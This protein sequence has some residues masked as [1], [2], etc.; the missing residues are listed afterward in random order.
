MPSIG[1]FTRSFAAIIGTEFGSV[2]K[3]QRVLRD[4][5]LLT[6]G[7]RGINAPELVPLDAARMLIAALVTDKPSLAPLAVVEF[8]NLPAAD[9]MLSARSEEGEIFA[10]WTDKMTFEQALAFLIEAASTAPPEHRQIL[11]RNI[12]VTCDPTEMKATL[13]WRDGSC[14]YSAGGPWL[15]LLAEGKTDRLDEVAAAQESARLRARAFA[16]YSAR[17]SI[18]RKMDGDL[19]L[20]VADLFR[21]NN[22]EAASEARRAG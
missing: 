18:N 11:T 9:A 2:M 22:I 17:I 19:L 14:S 20:E 4:A 10:G 7:A 13:S 21:S 6:T 1:E 8:G 12:Q 15:M 5:G 16:G 3:L